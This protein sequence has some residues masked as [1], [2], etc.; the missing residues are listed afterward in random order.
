[1]RLGIWK[2]ILLVLVLASLLTGCWD[3]RELE[4]QAFVVVIGIDEGEGRNN[5]SVTFQIANPQVG[6]SDRATAQNEPA[7]DIVTLSSPDFLTA[8]DL[9]NS[10]VTRRV[11]FSHAKILVVGEKLARSEHFFELMMATIRDP[12][13]RRGMN[14]IVSREKAADFI[15]NNK[16]QLET[17]PH[18]FYDFMVGRWED[19]G[20]VP[21][22][23]IN[24]FF[25][26]TEADDGL[27]LSIYGT[28]K[29][30]KTK[31]KGYEDD[32][33]PGEIETEGGDPVQMIGSAVFKEGRMI[34]RMSGEETR[35]ALNLREKTDADEMMVTFPDPLSKK[36]RVSLRFIM[37]NHSKVKVDV[38]RPRPLIS[39]Y[40]PL[41]VEIMSIPSAI[42]YVDDLEKQEI[43]KEGIRKGL[44]KKH[45]AFIKRTQE[46]FGADPFQWGLAVRREFWTR[47]EY[48][49]YHWMQ[50]YP[51]AE[52]HLE[53]D[54]KITRF[55]KQ[56][57]PQSIKQI[58]D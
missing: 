2:R 37:R 56:M 16:P 40:L 11:T 45:R 23:D 14:I 22:S 51:K 27:Y 47:D 58:K 38:H 19:T 52:V 48:E 28:A 12:Q 57:R 10:K 9:I 25:Q 6:S 41:E 46:E 20:L 1:M 50:Q 54:V 32:Y 21:I 26:R 30:H 42:N 7:S 53:Y 39:V 4:E 35:I 31:K 34:G 43:L 13:I 55:G 5:I 8:R 3:R 15:R 49:R 44:E 33:L 36:H 24:R 18:K 29:K 17:R